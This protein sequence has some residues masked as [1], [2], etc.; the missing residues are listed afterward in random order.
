MK[1][2]EPPRWSQYYNT[3]HI[4]GDEKVRENWLHICNFQWKCK[5]KMDGHD[6]WIR[7]WVFH[8]NKQLTILMTIG[9]EESMFEAS[10]VESKI[11]HPFKVDQDSSKFI[12]YQHKQKNIVR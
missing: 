4:D 3:K 7:V 9:W 5:A 8:E 6:Y 10:I 11:I 12:A 1:A 2:T